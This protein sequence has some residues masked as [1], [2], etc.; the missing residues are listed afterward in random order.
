MSPDSEV[1]VSSKNRIVLPAL[2]ALATAGTLALTVAVLLAT[3]VLPAT[4][5]D[6]AP[7]RLPSE[8]LGVGHVVVAEA[9]VQD[10]SAKVPVGDDAA[11][12]AAMTSIPSR[13]KA[14]LPKPKPKPRPAPRAVASASGTGTVAVPSRAGDGG[15]WQTAKASWYGP[16]FYGRKTASGA[17]L[18]ENMMNVAHKSLPFGTQIQF[19]Y[20]GRTVTAVVNDRG[21]FVGGRTFDLGPGTAKALGFGGV[22]TVRYRILGR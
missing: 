10:I 11:V 1:S 19:E 4:Y 6:A 7:V 15:G 2:A 16:G 5:A 20:R 8:V 14:P 21:P 9:A 17:V 13:A 12:P 3:G 18:T 22:Q